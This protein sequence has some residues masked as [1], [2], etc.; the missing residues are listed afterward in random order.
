M[1]LNETEKAEKRIINRNYSL[2]YL[3]EIKFTLF[4]E[5]IHL[6]VENYS[7]KAEHNKLYKEAETKG[8]D[9]YAEL[10][11]AQHAFLASDL[12]KEIRKTILKNNCLK[13]VRKASALSNYADWKTIIDSTSQLFEPARKAITL[14][15]PPLGAQNGTFFMKS[16]AE[17]LMRK[18]LCRALPPLTIAPLRPT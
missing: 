10:I 15:K 14:T 11:E 6:L 5:K 9:L 4:V 13:A 1:I 7:E 17:S 18:P 8:R 2:K 3:Q 16:G 12:P